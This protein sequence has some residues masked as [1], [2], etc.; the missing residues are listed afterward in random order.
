[1]ILCADTMG[2]ERK[3]NDI[4]IPTGAMKMFLLEVMNG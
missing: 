3:R 4:T 2:E 1:M